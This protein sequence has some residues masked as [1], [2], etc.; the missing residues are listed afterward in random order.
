MKFSQ[1]VYA[2]RCLAH[3]LIIYRCRCIIHFTDVFP[4]Y[5]LLS[6]PAPSPRLASSSSLHSSRSS[7]FGSLCCTVYMWS[8]FARISFIVCSAF[9][10]LRRFLQRRR[11]SRIS[12]RPSNIWILIKLQCKQSQFQ[13]LAFLCRKLCSVQCVVAIPE[14]LPTEI[15]TNYLSR[16]IYIHE[17]N[18]RNYA[19]VF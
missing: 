11:R 12:N 2:V 8:S 19:K 5:F 14:T 13:W 9:L 10:W 1:R 6:L 7:C 18:Q 15:A 16:N 17:R 3:T 4:L